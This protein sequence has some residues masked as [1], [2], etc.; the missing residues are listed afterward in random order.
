MK[1]YGPLSKLRSYL[2]PALAAIALAV[3]PMA[4][5]STGEE[6]PSSTLEGA[7]SGE[8]AAKGNGEASNAA[9]NGE[10]ANAG[11]ETLNSANGEKPEGGD[12]AA[13]NPIGNELNGAIGGDNAATAAAK[14]AAKAVPEEGAALNGETGSSG[15]ALASEVSPSA[16]ATGNSAGATAAPVDASKGGDPFSA[17]ANAAAPAPTNAGMNAS[18][19]APAPMAT[20][21][22]PVDASAAAPASASP[23]SPA[24]A[25]STTESAPLVSGPTTLPETGSKMAYY[26]MRGDTLGAIAQ[27]IYG[28]RAKWKALQSENGLS[29]A[30]KIYPGDVIYYT[31]NDA[32][33]AFAEKYESGARQTY[34]V[35]KGDT[36][37]QLAAKFY[38]TQGAW[39]A[40]WKENPQVTNPDRIRVGMVLSFRA[41]SKV[42]FKDDDSVENEVGSLDEENESDDASDVNS[43]ILTV[44]VE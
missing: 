27:K 14:N 40:V 41:A 26:V 34:T 22:A 3:G 16:G 19:A 32:S 11:S 7:A 37:S 42:A 2:L 23:A 17:G 8:N 4:C 43:E 29:D 6:E 39:R 33:K 28:N 44:S 15:N 24:P 35:A 12:G 20:E 18:A 13:S 1:R 30:N 21:S 38:G 31:L 9:L 36:L 10:T 25:A 5:S